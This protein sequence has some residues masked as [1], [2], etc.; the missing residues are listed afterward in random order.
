MHTHAHSVQHPEGFYRRVVA[1][2][3]PSSLLVD[4]RYHHFDSSYIF[5]RE[6]VSSVSVVSDYG[7]DDRAIG[8][9]S[10]AGARDLSSNLC[11]QTGSEAHP[12]S[13]TM[14]TGG[15]F[16]GAKRG[17]GVTLTTHPHLKPRS[18]MNRSYTS[19]SP[20]RHHCFAFFYVPLRQTMT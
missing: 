17:R 2:T 12:A 16:P 4:R 11:V 8:V 18:R 3:V 20:K 6:P 19:S 5:K 1:L 10:P 15:R 13:C 7:L 14:G 9:R